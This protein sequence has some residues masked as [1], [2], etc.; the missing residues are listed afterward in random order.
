MAT[1]QARRA[2]VAFGLIAGLVAIVVGMNWLGEDQTV[3]GT[4]LLVG[5]IVMLVGGIV[6]L[7]GLLRRSQDS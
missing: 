2:I 4:L 6:T 3:S 7:T 1:N 5:G